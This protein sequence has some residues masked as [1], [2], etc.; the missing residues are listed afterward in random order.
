M[1]PP[2]NTAMR[3]G[4]GVS[5]CNPHTRFVPLTL[6]F[7]KLPLSTA[8]SN[9]RPNK[10][11][12]LKVFDRK[13]KMLQRERAAKLEDAQ[14]YQYLKDE[15]TTCGDPCNLVESVRYNWIASVE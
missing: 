14:V 1:L 10:S 7:T 13:T 6:S 2:L 9:R 3:Y 11:A 8:T 4:L 5:C 12:G 15:V